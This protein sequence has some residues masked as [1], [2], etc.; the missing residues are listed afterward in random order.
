M[1]TIIIIVL[2][3][4]VGLV[5]IG[6]GVDA[7]FSNIGEG[8]EKVK[9]NEK[10]QEVKEQISSK[11]TSKVEQFDTV[12][13]NS[14]SDDKS[15]KTLNCSGSAKCVLET[16]TRIVD[17]DTLYTTNYKIRLSLTDT[18]EINESGYS[19]ATSF[20]GKMCPIGSSILI[21]Q[22]DKQ[23]YDA[24][25]RLLANVYC[26]GKSLNS[27]LLYNGYAN[28]LTEYCS[29]SEFSDEIWAQDFGCGAKPTPSIQ[30]TTESSTSQTSKSC[31][32]SYPDFCIPSSP[33]DLDCKDISQ[34]KFTVLQPDPH[35]FDGDKDGIGCES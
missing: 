17:G 1:K 4:I 14:I 27:A 24:Y 13:E 35:R 7:F 9:Q 26:D 31:D 5:I 16:V 12:I 11:I 10:L 15:S 28:I 22:D 20:T 2:A 19:T 25:G 30:P 33:P 6:G 32:P 23:H 34:K 8:T 29:T 18:P 3:V 21:D